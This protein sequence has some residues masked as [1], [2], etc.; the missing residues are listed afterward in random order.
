MVIQPGDA[1]SVRGYASVAFYVRS[2]DGDIITAVMVGDDKVH[3]V[4][5]N[6]CTV[7]TEDEYCE[8]CG[9]LGCG[10]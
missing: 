7:I 4:D 1:I 2:V 9:Q 8:I 5:A 6:D 10:H 3:T